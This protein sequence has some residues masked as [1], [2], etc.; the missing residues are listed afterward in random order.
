MLP[1]LVTNANILT[2]AVV[3]EQKE[4]RSA[5][6]LSCQTYLLPLSL[7]ILIKSRGKRTVG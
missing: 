6:L 5:M 3:L 7:R 2:V 4:L 1:G